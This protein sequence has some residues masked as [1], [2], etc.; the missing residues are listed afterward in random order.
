MSAI[1][2]VISPSSHRRRA[3]R[4]E[5]RR[6]PKRPPPEPSPEE[7]SEESEE[8]EN[9]SDITSDILLANCL[10]RNPTRLSAAAL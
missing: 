9:D 5:A 8:E 3:L 4:L 6:P 10:S 2:A 1:L 7:A